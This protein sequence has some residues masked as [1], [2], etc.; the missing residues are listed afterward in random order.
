MLIIYRYPE[1]PLRFISEELGFEGDEE[2][3]D[4]LLSYV[5][6]SVLPIRNEA[7][8]FVTKSIGSIFEQAKAEAFRVVDIKGQL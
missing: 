5:N 3:R 4:F 6:E 7:F 8:H 1:V 2:A